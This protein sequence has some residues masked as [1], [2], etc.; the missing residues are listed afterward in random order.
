MSKKSR[1]QKRRAK[2]KTEPAAAAS[3]PHASIEKISKTARRKLQKKRA[4]E[5]AAATRGPPPAKAP[6]CPTAAK[7]PGLAVLHEDHDVL[8]INKPAGLLCHP[9]PGFWESGTV[10]HAL[11][12]RQRL[13]GFSVIAPEM[14]EARQS[15][16]G[17]DDSFIPRVVVHRLDR[18]TTGLML[19]AKTPRA[20]MRLAEAFKGRTT[21][22]WYVALLAGRIEPRRAGDAGRVRLDGTALHVDLPI[23]KDAAR[24]GKMVVG[25]GGKSAQSV[26]H[27]HGWSA[28]ANATLVTVQLL[29][30]RQ[31]QIRVHCAHLGA[32]LVN[33]D[34]Y[35]TADGV[36][37]WRQ[38]CAGLA[39]GR[40][41]LHA[42]SMEVP[43][44]GEQG[45]TLAVRAPLPPDLADAIRRVFP[46]AGDDPAAW[47]EVAVR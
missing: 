11:E 16:T 28:E 46:D 43:H 14:L 15:H 47:P 21:S 7:P 32:P 40:P 24:P 36:R 34:A 10:F 27:V 13:A 29:T 6:S 1:E 45:G 20:E 17:E 44:P 18:G 3:E 33:D 22:K 30:G 26:L 25:R 8:A 19:L 38:R 37:A 12:Q 31:H 39:R 9:S 23:D 35:G 42:W 41:L 2:E 5:S 4:R